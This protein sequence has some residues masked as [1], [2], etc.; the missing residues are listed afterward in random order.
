MS[1]L[2]GTLGIKA[3]PCNLSHVVDSRLF[4]RP[5][6]QA[7]V[8]DQCKPQQK[9]PMVV[10]AIWSHFEWLEFET[11]VF[12]WMNGNSW[13]NGAAVIGAHSFSNVIPNAPK[14]TECCGAVSMLGERSLHSPVKRHECV[15]TIF[16]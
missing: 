13:C 10:D 16:D 4:R 7:L 6:Q 8:K 9:I 2:A 15:D 11:Q 12:L 14:I 3:K 1:A 5:S